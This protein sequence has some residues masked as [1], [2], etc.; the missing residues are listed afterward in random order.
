LVAE[1]GCTGD[2]CLADIDK[3]G[4]TDTTDLV[5]IVSILGTSCE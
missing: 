1:L 5:N 2:S 3:D 4:D